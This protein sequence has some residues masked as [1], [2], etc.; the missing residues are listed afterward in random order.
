MGAALAI[1]AYELQNTNIQVHQD[2][3]S[4]FSRGESTTPELNT[5]LAFSTCS[6]EQG[7]QVESGQEP[8]LEHSMPSDRYVDK[9]EEDSELED[10]TVRLRDGVRIL[11]EQNIGTKTSEI[12]TN[13]EIPSLT[14]SDLSEDEDQNEKSQIYQEQLLKVLKESMY[15]LFRE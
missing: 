8:S 9:V 13:S 5:N 7:L 12:L 11:I 1:V 14:E 15:D 3:D 10:Y 4:S 2:V 6:V